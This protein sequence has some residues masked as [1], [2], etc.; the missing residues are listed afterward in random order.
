MQP[1]FLSYFYKHSAE[2]IYTDEPKT[3]PF[4][5]FVVVFLNNTYSGRLPYEASIFTAEC[6]Q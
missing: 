3:N 1:E 2:H 6:L 5:G 4:V